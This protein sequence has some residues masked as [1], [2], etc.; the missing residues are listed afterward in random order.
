MSRLRR[1]LLLATLLGTAGACASA[2][3]GERAQEVALPKPD[4]ALDLAQ[5][6]TG[7]LKVFDNGLK[8]FVVPDPNTRLVQLD[9][10]QA[11]G[12]RDDP[13]GKSGMAHFVEHL[14]F[15]LPTAGA[16]SP[17]VMSELQRRSLGFNA[18][19]S[20][21][22]THYM[23]TGTLDDLE[24]YFEYTALRLGYGCDVVSD[25]AF[26]RER[27]VVRN[28]HRWRGE[29]VDIFVL[30]RVLEL[31]FPE[32]HPYR[33]PVMG[34]DHELASITREDVCGFVGQH[35][36]A[37]QASVVVT[38]GVDPGAV[39]ELAREHLER[40]PK[41]PAAARAKVGRPTLTGQKVQIK[42]PV[43]KP[44]AIILFEE[45]RR[46]SR[47]YAAALAARTTMFM[48]I[49][50]YT[51]GP[52]SFVDN[53]YPASLGGKLSPLFGVGVESKRAGQ[54]DAAVDEVMTAIT[55]GFSPE[56]KDKE[57]AAAY[58]PARQRVRLQV[59]SS[60]ASVT[61]RADTFADYLEQPGA[62]GFHGAELAALD[63]L[64]AV[65]AQEVGRYLFTRE[66]A[67]I[68]EVIP[69]G[70][71]DKPKA[72]RAS[73]DY[74]RGEEEAL[75]LP[76]D[77]DPAEA[78]RPLPLDALGAMILAT[79]EGKFESGLRVM[80][81]RS[82]QI[83]VMEVQVI[84][85]AGEVDARAQPMIATLAAG[86]YGLREG[87]RDAQTLM[88]YFNYAG[89]IYGWD[90]GA[91]STTFVS[92][93]LSIY[94]DFIIAG[95]GERVVQAEYRTGAIEMWKQ[96]RGEAL[97]KTHGQQ[98]A[99]RI[100]AFHTAL[101]GPGHPHVREVIAD[102]KALRSL[103][104]ADVE[105]YRQ[106]H[107]RASN[108]TVIVTGGFDIELAK[109]Y[110]ERFFGAPKLRD[111]RSTWLTPLADEARPTPP[112]PQPGAI[113][114]LTEIDK[115]RVQT[116][117]TI[118]FPLAEV[119]G[120]RHAALQVMAEMLDF[121]VGAVRHTMGASYGVYGRLDDD[122]PQ[123]AVGGALD[124]AR[125][126]EGLAAIRA[127]IQRLRDGEDFDRRF[128]FAR[129]NVLRA[130]IDVQSDPKALADQLARAVRNGRSYRYFDELTRDVANLTPAAVQAEIARVLDERRSVTLVQGPAEGV[131]G[132]V[133]GAGL[134]QVQALPEVVHD[135]DD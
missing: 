19:T 83:P 13:A 18:Y 85:G 111:G 16:G 79:S 67:M 76:D 15:Q 2:G 98:E 45:P 130:L 50:V 119:Y 128:A 100:N 115:E 121:E 125:A 4:R 22:E 80:L 26:L 96:G 37:S 44:T 118:G 78:H 52:T 135:E 59:L 34:K 5:S 68:V 3:V 20:N 89:G 30:D 35:Y 49:G 27:E 47:D 95:V 112:E 86:A 129:R 66:R 6:G 84:V 72:E 43:K 88:E 82:S 57:Y 31:V 33:R 29:G 14:M 28:E 46:F 101:Y 74:T 91:L 64:T 51:G 108:T 104:L 58:D 131:A 41:R 60:I 71:E 114:A 36:N 12:T 75:S 48:A 93:G 110:I 97:R 7:Y 117:V 70:S 53:A 39:L 62:P 77:I 106:T 134:T 24:A 1:G 8:L 122:R 21:D 92:R 69:D 103:S 63:E 10:R 87:N 73:F 94:L 38:G 42:A 116:T 40:L 56:L 113:R 127:A 107:Y 81:V 126:G 102:R 32:G 65:R 99:A 9:V 23:H 109:A 123:V 11:V 105:R 90:V 132:A 133:T 55:R 120:P 61:S 17:K 25:E 124:S 54:L